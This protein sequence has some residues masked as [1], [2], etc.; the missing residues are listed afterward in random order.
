MLSTAALV[1]VAAR[2]TST[3]VA[4]GGRAPG[5]AAVGGNASGAAGGRSGADGRRVGKESHNLRELVT[6]CIHQFLE[7]EERPSLDERREGLHHLKEGREILIL[8]IHAI[9]HGK[10]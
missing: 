5:G 2:R 4:V 9:D 7:K 1:G 8:C 6:M 3:G 10:H